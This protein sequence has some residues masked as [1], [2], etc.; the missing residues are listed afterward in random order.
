MDTLR[1]CLVGALL[2]LCPAMAPAQVTDADLRTAEQQLALALTTK[3]RATFE[4]L[5]AP[6]FILRGA[7]DVARDTWITNALTMCWGD[8]FDISDFTVAHRTAD[9][10]IVSLVLTTQQDPVTC[11]RAIVRSLLTDVWVTRDDAPRLLV[12]HSGPAGDVAAQFA[13]T[14]PPPP[15]W[16]GS[17]ELSLVATGGN[18]DTQTL[19]TAASLIWRPGAWTTRSRAAFVRS[20]TDDATT[21]ESL[22]FE[23]RQS[24]ALTERIDIFA[25]GNLL[26]DR[27]AGID[28]RTTADAGLGWTLLDDDTH[29]LKVD[30]GAGVTHEARVTGADETFA[31]GTAG[32]GYRWRLSEIA[33]LNEQALF[34]TD[35]GTPANWRLQNGLSVTVA[36]SRL[37]SVKVSHEVKQ[38]NRPVAGFGRTDTIVS[39]ALVAKFQRN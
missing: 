1:T 10:A 34:S 17:A 13:K 39:A 24:R 22:V 6:E 25:R 8:T 35:L 5:L 9:T 20:A 33:E 2:F 14:D 27:F 7:P 12:R 31:A 11:E 29:M 38:L 23:L 26:V 3:D 18:T 36:I 21:A 19:G 16:E 15:R 32:L 37:L 4:R 30:T 28:N